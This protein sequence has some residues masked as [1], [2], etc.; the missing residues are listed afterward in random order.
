MNSKHSVLLQATPGMPYT[1][2]F[3]GAANKDRLD[4]QAHAPTEDFG[5]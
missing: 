1:L 5:V 4:N 2:I 3:T